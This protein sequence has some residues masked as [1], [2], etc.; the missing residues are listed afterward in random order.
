MSI[1]KGVDAAASQV[2]AGADAKRRDGSNRLLLSVGSIIVALTTALSMLGYGATLA[3]ESDFGIPRSAVYGSP[4]ELLDLSSIAIS[5]FLDLGLRAL[6]SAAFYRELFE[7][8]SWLM[9]LGAA[10]LIILIIDW[11]F[12]ARILRLMRSLKARVAQTRLQTRMQGLRG[13]SRSAW[14]KF[15]ALSLAA[16]VGMVLALALMLCAIAMIG[17]LPAWGMQASQHHLQKWV[18][19][20]E[21]CMPLRGRQARLERR[22]DDGKPKK[23]VAHCVS[24]TR[25][26]K[27]V[28][29]R[30]LFSTSSALVL[31]NPF[32]GSVTRVPLAETVVE[33]VPEIP[34]AAASA[35]S[36][37]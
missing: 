2:E 3:G 27:T 14:A 25:N 23:R 22:P 32:D 29:G 17:F 30:V 21:G 19:E 26:G 12:G 6:A 1:D 4:I 8:S 18:V 31:F 37:P 13:P 36:A 20:P 35:P 11:C 28:T 15:A 24:A 34:A 16:P 5:G 7:R 33:P 9:W 10:F